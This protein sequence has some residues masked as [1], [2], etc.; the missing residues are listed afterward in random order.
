MELVIQVFLGLSAFGVLLVTF[1]LWA[2]Y[3]KRPKT[4]TKADWWRE[5]VIKRPEVGGSEHERL[6]ELASSYRTCVCAAFSGVLTGKEF[7][8]DMNPVLAR[9]GGKFEGAVKR[10][11]WEEA[12]VLIDQIEE[13]ALALGGKPLPYPG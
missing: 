10:S 7:S 1:Y 2:V 8:Y 9:L 13:R 5:W 11:N 3:S 12:L 6:V 4:K